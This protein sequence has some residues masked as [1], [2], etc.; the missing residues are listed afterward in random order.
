MNQKVEEYK[1]YIAADDG[2]H[3]LPYHTH[4]TAEEHNH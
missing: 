1:Y 3:H 2:I 4:Q